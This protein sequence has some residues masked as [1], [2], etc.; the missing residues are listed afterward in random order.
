MI[1]SS[2]MREAIASRGGTALAADAVEG[3]AVAALLVLQ[4][5]RSLTLERGTVVEIAGRHGVAGPGF[6]DGDSTECRYRGG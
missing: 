5:E 2:V 1:W 6:H 4:D 3:V